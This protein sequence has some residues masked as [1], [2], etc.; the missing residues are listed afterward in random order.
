MIALFGDVILDILF[1]NTASSLMLRIS[2]PSVFFISIMQLSGAILQ[3]LGY[4]G[5][6]FVSSVTVGAIKL[7]AAV[8]LVSVPDINIYGAPIGS[9]IAFFVGMV[10]NLIFLVRKTH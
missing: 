8:F 1:S 10:M 4:T 6:V 5:R 3:A 2:A 9:D 7:L